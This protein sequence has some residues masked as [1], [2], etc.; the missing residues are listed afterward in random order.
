M[1]APLMRSLAQTQGRT[2][3]HRLT[4]AGKGPLPGERRRLADAPREGTVERLERMGERL[5]TAASWQE[6]LAEP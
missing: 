2:R 4:Q 3:C 5:L 6:L 1:R